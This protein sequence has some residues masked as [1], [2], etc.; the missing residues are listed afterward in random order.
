MGSLILITG[1]ARSGKSSYAEK[2]LED[3]KEVLY[4]AT[5]CICDQEMQERV[6]EHLS[7]RDQSWKTLELP[8]SPWEGLKGRNGGYILIDCLAVWISNI[9]LTY[10]NAEIEEVNK[11]FL[12]IKNEILE[13]ADLFLREMEKSRCQVIAVTN[14]VGAGI[15]PSY[16]LGRYYRDILGIVNQKFAAAAK[17]VYWCTCGI[18]V[19]IK[20]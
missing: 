6:E 19:K 11:P 10:W 18:P 20:A 3:Q 1:G 8:Y 16:Q 9:L 7:R 12:E 2:L 5:A 15:V 14:E 4:I 13:K 17:E